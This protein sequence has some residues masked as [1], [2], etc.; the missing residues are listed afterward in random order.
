MPLILSGQVINTTKKLSI[1][2]KTGNSL[3][4]FH[5]EILSVGVNGAKSDLYSIKIDATTFIAWSKAQGHTISNCVR[6]YA[7]SQD[8]GGMNQGL[9]L[10]TK[11]DLPNIVTD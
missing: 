10:A 8:G 3:E 6:P 5:V 11:T 2:R 7:M 9:S 1:D 4:V